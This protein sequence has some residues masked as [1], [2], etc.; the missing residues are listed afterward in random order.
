MKEKLYSR[1]KHLVGFETD[2]S[3]RVSQQLYSLGE[4]DNRRR[5]QVTVKPYSPAIIPCVC[6][7]YLGVSEH[8][9]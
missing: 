3:F 1:K 8:R 7:A 6:A 4:N 2:K 9:D 5:L